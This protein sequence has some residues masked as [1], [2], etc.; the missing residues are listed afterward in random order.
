MSLVVAA[1]TSLALQAAEPPR[2]QIS[3]EALG[4]MLGSDEVG[5][6][7][8]RLEYFAK[9]MRNADDGKAEEI[10]EIYEARKGISDTYTT[11]DSTSF[12]YTTAS[13]A[14]EILTPFLD[15]DSELKRVNAALALS[16]MPQVTIQPALEKMIVHPSPSVRY[17]GWE[18]YRS[19]WVRVVG[20]GPL[21]TKTMFASLAKRAEGE[22]SAHVMGAIWQM[23]QLRADVPP[24]PP[25]GMRPP[26]QLAFDILRK[27]WRKRCRQIHDGSLPMAKVARK[28]IAAVI[29]H[30][31]APGGGKDK[32]AAICQM[33]C[34]MM[35]ASA[36]AYEAD[37]IAVGDLDNAGD[38]ATAKRK[39]PLGAVGRANATL[40][41]RCEM[42]LNGLLGASQAKRKDYIHAVLT[43]RRLSRKDRGRRMVFWEDLDT[44]KRYGA[45]WW[46]ED[47]K[48]FGVR[49][50]DFEKTGSR[51]AATTKRGPDK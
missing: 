12:R 42:A 34:D 33:L 44:G 43:D 4:G 1:A 6:I 22:D 18:G 45:M 26:K 21:P 28:A 9:I 25:R 17:L 11:Y 23:L 20:Q 14:A 29:D 10:S 35:Y 32:T 19:A 5:Q 48:K 51:P 49:K 27:T 8:E 31:T 36:K 2:L 46:L 50:P 15:A 7:R 41:L 47:L 24:D 38:E 40:L 3:K 16:A 39:K 37:S 13:L 30:A